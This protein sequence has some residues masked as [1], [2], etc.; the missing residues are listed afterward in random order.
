MSGAS[1]AVLLLAHQAHAPWSPPEPPVPW[2]CRGHEGVKA[3]RAAVGAPLHLEPRELQM[4][5]GVLATAVAFPIFTAASLS[6]VSPTGLGKGG[7]CLLSLVFDDFTCVWETV[8]ADSSCAH[9][10][11]ARETGEQPGR[12]L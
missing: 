10:S 8:G 2:S 3:S 11:T 7:V 6:V 4:F 1:E 9:L 5:A 12:M